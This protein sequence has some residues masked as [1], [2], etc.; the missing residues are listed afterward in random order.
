MELLKSSKRRSFLSEAVYI[1]LNIALAG[2]VLA[3]IISTESLLPAVAL[4]LLSKWRVLAVRPRYWI[5][6]IKA[7]L[8]DV[9]V[10]LSFVVMLFAAGEDAFYLQI[11]LTV[12]YVG[13]LLFVKPRSK[14]IFITAQAGVALFLGTTA[15]M[16]VSYDWPSVFVAAAMWLIGYST[17]RHVLANYEDPHRSFY[18]LVWG[19]VMAEIGWLAY[20]WTF[21]YAI[22][23]FGGVQL[24]QTAIIV[25]AISFMVERVYASY[26]R[27]N[28]VKSSEVTLP[29]L[30][31]VS[32]V[33]ILMV[34]FNTLSAGS[35]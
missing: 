21:A 19:F 3:V 2:A 32:V 6:N 11:A 26:H 17:A 24:S 31:S 28:A 8:V 34:F 22:P 1:V 35:I 12:L 15:L 7:N 4:I 14:R 13:W 9:I 5:T 20:H 18:S 25:L 33:L 23:G 16:T 27:H 10:S 30:L 29:I